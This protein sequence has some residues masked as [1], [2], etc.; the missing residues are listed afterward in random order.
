MFGNK[1]RRILEHMD[2]AVQFAQD[3]IGQVAAGFRLAVDIDRHI[4]VLPPHFLDKATQVQNR[5]VKIRT[6]AE[7]LIVDRQHKSTG[8]RL[9]LRKLGQITIAGHTQHLEPFLLDG[10][11]HGADTKAR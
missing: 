1:F 9:L 2:E 6:G 7:F 3:I 10:F 8:P 5:R 4:G 11:S